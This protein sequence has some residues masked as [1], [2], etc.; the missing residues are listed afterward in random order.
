M[1]SRDKLVYVE[2]V[3]LSAWSKVGDILPATGRWKLYQHKA[4]ILSDVEEIGDWDADQPA[5][6]V[7]AYQTRAEKTHRGGLWLVA[8]DGKITAALWIPIPIRS[9]G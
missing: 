7:R 2:K 1:P 5:V 9:F 4:R 8:P 6:A 3:N